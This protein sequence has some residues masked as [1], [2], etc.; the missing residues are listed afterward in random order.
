MKLRRKV[1]LRKGNSR[2]ENRKVIA[3]V[4]ASI[5]PESFDRK[6]QNKTKT[7]TKLRNHL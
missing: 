6:E 1:L 2:L 7:T 5:G 4:R 3:N